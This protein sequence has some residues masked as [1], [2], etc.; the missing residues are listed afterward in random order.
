VVKLNKIYTRTGDSG[1]TGLADGARRLK[2][3]ARIRAFGSIDEANSMIGVARLYV[4]GFE[5]FDPL[6][7][8]VQND[9]FDLGA[10]LAVPEDGQ[11]KSWT[12]I[13]IKAAQVTALEADIDR[14]N[15]ELSPLNSFI[16]PAGNPLSAHLHLARTIA[17]RAESDLVALMHTPDEVVNPEALKY[18]NRLSDLL[19]VLARY[20][21]NKGADDV[22]WVPST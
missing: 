21:N 20:A 16:L 10:D 17:R 7:A 19:F 14:Y 22:L 1:D 2:S 8:Q 18:F 13:R 15:A 9:L 4:A 6:L 11:P 3:D 12:P 5:G